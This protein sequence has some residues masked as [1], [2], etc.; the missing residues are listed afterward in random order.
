MSELGSAP[1]RERAGAKKRKAY[2]GTAH[3]MGCAGIESDRCDSN[4]FPRW[5]APQLLTALQFSDAAATVHHH[6]DTTTRYGRA[7]RSVRSV[8]DS[9]CCE[10]SGWGIDRP[11]G[12][13][14]GFLLP[15]IFV[16]TAL[17]VSCDDEDAVWPPEPREEAGLAT[18]AHLFKEAFK[19]P[20]R[21]TRRTIS[22]YLAL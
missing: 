14:P 5:S 6:I 9:R 20:F 15:V 13:A 19:E 2:P 10:P 1:S 4:A 7:E 3:I 21:V 8:S 16:P 11:E 18:D 22:H 12:A 17:N